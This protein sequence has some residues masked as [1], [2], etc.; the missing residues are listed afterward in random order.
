MNRARR[1]RRK[2]AA[3]GAATVI[4]LSL[5]ALAS[6]WT[7][8]FVMPGELSPPHATLADRCD[9]CHTDATHTVAR[10]FRALGGAGF[11]A[12][13]VSDNHCLACHD[14]GS[15][16]FAPHSVDPET[17]TVRD[18]RAD[19]SP[20]V[21]FA[22]AYTQRADLSCVTCH[23]EHRGEE[24]SLTHLSDDQCQ[25]C[26]V[27]RF[28]SFTSGHPAFE[29][30][31]FPDPQR[32]AFDHDRHFNVHFT[33]ADF[34]DR[35]PGDCRACHVPDSSGHDMT[36]GSY[37]HTC[38][39]CHADDIRGVAR[40]TDRGVPF[41]ALPAVDVVTLR[42]RGFELGHWPADARIAETGITP[43]LA[44]LLST[45]TDAATQ[46]ATLDDVDLVDLG[47]ADEAGMQAA[48]W[49][50]WA[51]RDLL[52]DIAQRGHIA[53][54]ERVESALHRSLSADETA[55]L[56][57]GLPGDTLAA[58]ID[59]WLPDLHEELEAR[60]AGLPLPAHDHVAPTPP[61]T[62]PTG[63]SDDDLEGDL[64]GG[65][66]DDLLGDDLLGNDEGDPFAS[67]PSTTPADQASHPDDSWVAFGGW[68]LADASW[69]LHYRPVG[70]AD[71]FMRAWIDAAA[72]TS[73][74]A[75]LDALATPDAPGAC[76]KCHTRTP[77][78][79]A[80]RTGHAR[81]TSASGLDHRP[82]TRFSHAPH[83][84]MVDSADGCRTCHVPIASTTRVDG[85]HAVHGFENI[86]LNQCTSC[87]HPEG[88]GSSC[89]Q[90]HNY[91]VGDFSRVGAAPLPGTPS[92]R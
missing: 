90:C 64:L 88:A 63:T 44:L 87:H 7:P 40:A 43:F 52:D 81:P 13:P 65:G 30:Y 33:D 70:H 17:L 22:H 75:L 12:G 53:I 25:T 51:T 76:I 71:P 34:I 38:A 3:W 26:H 10:G 18:L 2:F 29:R 23:R 56:L 77:R 68:H 1:R 60:R 69:G 32:I 59:R 61:P 89:L 35:A 49:L 4:G 24:S 36:V 16:P 72:S 80:W 79:V 62:A 39:A 20:L 21:E 82:W 37:E 47:N 57:A 58:A 28:G 50:T 86:Q 19:G 6:P 83:L 66:G 73:R 5:L 11:A 85:L 42:A 78:G 67:T 41:L 9:L 84:T 48:A 27:Q 8:Q 14:R 92:T 15:R 91:H 46:L 54:A 55:A 45:R 31:P 74:T